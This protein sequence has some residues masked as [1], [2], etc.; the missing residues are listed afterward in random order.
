MDED[1]KDL[2][3]LHN[4]ERYEEIS[5]DDMMKSDSK[6]DSLYTSPD[7]SDEELE[8]E[9]ETEANEFWQKIKHL[10]DD[11]AKESLEIEMELPSRP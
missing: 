11:K 9:D 6:S 10:D 4:D 2:E 7:D 5:S 1:K 3:K 8:D